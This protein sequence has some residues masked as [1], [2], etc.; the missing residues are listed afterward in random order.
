MQQDNQSEI[1]SWTESEDE[2]S[3]HTAKRRKVDINPTKKIE[4]ISLNV[5]PNKKKT[6]NQ[7]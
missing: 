7:Q 4:Q 1:D 5:L 6:Q 3:V 2:L